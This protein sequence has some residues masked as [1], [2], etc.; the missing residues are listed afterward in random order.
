M[1]V[2]IFILKF[3][4]PAMAGSLLCAVA[5]LFAER[6]SVI[7]LRTSAEKFRKSN[8]GR[9]T[10]N[11]EMIPRRLANHCR[12]SGYQVIPLTLARKMG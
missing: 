7:E 1:M 12:N 10:G 11:T 4:L 2:S 9:M 3:Q 8:S 6:R 5:A